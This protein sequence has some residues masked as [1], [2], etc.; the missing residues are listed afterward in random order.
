MMITTRKGH[1]SQ[2]QSL[3]LS[4]NREGELGLGGWKNTCKQLTHIDFH[5]DSQEL[6]RT[7]VTF[8]HSL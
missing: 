4:I 6:R 7:Q 8:P 2:L 5:I 1:A 3:D